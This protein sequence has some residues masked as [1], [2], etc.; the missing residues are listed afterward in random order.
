MLDNKRR[1][2]LVRLIRQFK[3]AEVGKDQ[4]D[5]K[6]EYCSVRGPESMKNSNRVYDFEAVRTRKMRTIARATTMVSQP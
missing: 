4:I 5:L 1:S 2:L 3:N 6:A